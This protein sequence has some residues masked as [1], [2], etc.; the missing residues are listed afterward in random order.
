MWGRRGSR[1]AHCAA[2]SWLQNKR[3]RLG[4][5]FPGARFRRDQGLT[6]FLH[7]EEALNKLKMLASSGRL[8]FTLGSERVL[9]TG[10][11][12]WSRKSRARC[13]A[14]ISGLSCTAHQRRSRSNGRAIPTRCRGSRKRRPGNWPQRRSRPGLHRSCWLLTPLGG[15]KVSRRAKGSS[16]LLRNTQLAVQSNFERKKEHR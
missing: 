12:W 7:F 14:S 3:N 6:K 11:R 9:P 15:G 8:V 5:A 1:P 4:F 10:T 2:A 13:A 16:S